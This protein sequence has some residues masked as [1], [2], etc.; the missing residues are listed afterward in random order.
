MCNHI[1]VPVAAKPSFTIPLQHQFLASDEDLLWE[2]EA[3]GIPDVDYQ[4][5][6]NSELLNIET[7]PPEDQERYKITVSWAQRNNECLWVTSPD[8]MKVSPCLRSNTLLKKLRL[9]KL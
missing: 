3:F 2:C 8:P 1:S 7:M 5:L 4:W 9:I 6:R